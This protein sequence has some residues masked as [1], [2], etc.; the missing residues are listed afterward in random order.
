M[1]RT[2]TRGLVG[3]VA[4]CATLT[5]SL[6]APVEP[7]IATPLGAGSP[8]QEDG[9]CAEP[10]LPIVGLRSDGHA[11]PAYAVW[12]DRGTKP[13]ILLGDDLDHGAALRNAGVDTDGDGTADDVTTDLS[14][15]P[16]AVVI[17]R[18]DGTVRVAL[19]GHS[20]IALTDF[21]VGDL[22]ADGRDELLLLSRDPDTATDRVFVLPGATTP[23]EHQADQTGIEIA[24]YY[25]LTA[26]G[27]Q[28]D[29][30]GRDLLVRSGGPP[31][32]EPRTSTLVSG[33][34]LM[35]VGPGST[36]PLSGDGPTLDGWPAGVFD[37]GDAKPALATSEHGADGS[38]LVHLWRD[39][40]ATRFTSPAEVTFPSAPS[41]SMARLAADGGQLILRAGHADRGGSL[42]LLW[43]VHDPCRELPRAETLLPPVV[44]GPTP[45]G[46][47]PTA[48]GA[49]AVPARPSYTG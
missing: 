33:D 20:T 34:R 39:G 45:H 41:V 7:T 5:A 24:T 22:D 35:A 21:P 10:Y 37:V 11:N 27:D 25:D 30:P 29:G 2:G 23:G 31:G 40:E 16:E 13:P 1:R 44:P 26:A 36:A 46:D 47:T 8:A 3:L 4:G 9:S 38:V 17:D 42:A 15:V 28:I 18:G 14:T 49:P 32:E 19:D 6:V 48:P 43:D 12:P